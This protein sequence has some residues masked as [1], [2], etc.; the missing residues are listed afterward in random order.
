MRGTGTPQAAPTPGKPRSIPSCGTYS[1]AELTLA[2]E[3]AAA[4]RALAEVA[5][6]TLT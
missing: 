5:G 4:L 6:V 2:R 3:Q 1:D